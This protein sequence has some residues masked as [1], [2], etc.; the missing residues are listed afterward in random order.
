MSESYTITLNS[1]DT[2][3]FA[4]HWTY[5]GE[6]TNKLLLYFKN[7]YPSNSVT[8]NSVSLWLGTGDGYFYAGDQVTGGGGEFSTSL[9]GNSHSSTPS[10][11]RDVIYPTNGYPNYNATNW[12]SHTFTFS[13]LTI[14]PSATVAIYISTPSASVSGGT[15]LCIDKGEWSSRT[16]SINITVVPNTVTLSYNANGGSGAPSSQQLTPGVAGTVSST[17]PTR[18][19]YTFDS[20]NTKSDRTG[21]RYTS[22]SSITISSATTLYAIWKYSVSYN[23]NGGS[24]AP[25][26]QTNFYGT[27]TTLTSNTPTRTGY[28]FVRW[29]TKSDGTGTNYNSGASYPYSSGNVTLY[30]VWQRK[31]YIWKRDNGQWVA[32]TLDGIWIRE[33]GQW[34]AKLPIWKYNNGWS[35]LL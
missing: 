2:A 28:N 6:G 24:S 35:K 29:N 11:V 34:V 5:N 25:S 26:S 23:A 1:S 32:L 30:A 4:E 9:S 21:T 17:V 33:N 12:G 27:N 15:V 14:A 18:S 3:Y 13:G 16:S 31:L 7:P 8:I 19:G 20:W 22:G 10:D